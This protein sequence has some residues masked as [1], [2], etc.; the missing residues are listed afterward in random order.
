VNK[1]TIRSRLRSAR[2]TSIGGKDRV[3]RPKNFY[4]EPAV[5]AAC[6]DLLQPIPKADK[7][8]FF[9]QNNIRH[10]TIC[11][12]FNELGLSQRAITRRLRTL[13]ITPV[14]GKDSS[15]QIQSFYPE[16]AVRELCK[17]LIEMKKSN[18]KPR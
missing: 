8:G 13:S 1:T 7:S 2:V 17:D 4:P 6:A 12:W 11:A 5:C 9:V 18:P 15:G 16:P 14:I 10:G 3:G